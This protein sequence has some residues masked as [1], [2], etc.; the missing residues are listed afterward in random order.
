MSE[1]IHEIILSTGKSDGQYLASAKCT[2]G[3]SHGGTY[4][5][6][7]EGPSPSFRAERQW[8]VH[9]ADVTAARSPRIGDIDPQT[10]LPLAE[11]EIELL[12]GM[13]AV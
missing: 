11:W 6:G 9:L 13:C 4:F 10:K 2:C 12:S 7:P 8:R 3:W 5:S 1:S